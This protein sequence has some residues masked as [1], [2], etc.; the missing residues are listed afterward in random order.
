MG[1]EP[2]AG[3]GRAAGG[4]AAAGPGLGPGPGPGPEPGPGGAVGCWACSYHG[5]RVAPGSAGAR[6]RGDTDA[7]GNGRCALCGA[8]ETRGLGRALAG[9]GLAC[10]LAGAGGLAGALAGAVV[11]HNG[12]FLL[13]LN[14]G[15][16]A[17]AGAEMALRALDEAALGGEQFQGRAT[18]GPDLRPSWLLR[19]E[20]SFQALMELP[21][22]L[23]AAL[24]ARRLLAFLSWTRLLPCRWLLKKMTHMGLG[25]A[26]G[27]VLDDRRGICPY[28]LLLLPWEPHPAGPARA[29]RPSPSCPICLSTY[30]QGEHLRHLPCGH[31]YHAGCIDPWLRLSATCPVCRGKVGG[32]E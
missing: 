16:G 31:V 10:G 17:F 1:V 21:V 13:P 8:S 24:L 12:A 29:A 11:G 3:A 22:G 2:R 18:E 30:K 32:K 15:R 9:C 25:S 14:A 23:A 28:E 20:E 19:L 26:S 7:G 4:S 5:A 6:A 27:V